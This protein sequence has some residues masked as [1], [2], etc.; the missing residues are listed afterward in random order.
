M[1][2][3]CKAGTVDILH[4][5]VRHQEFLLPAHEHRPTMQRVGHGE[6]RL[7]EIIP[8]MSECRK[9]CPMDH[10]LLLRCAPVEGQKAITTPNYLGVEVGGELGPVIGETADAQVPA[11]VR[12]GKVDILLR[13]DI[14]DKGSP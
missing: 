5:M 11:Q 12:R 7:L 9:P 10:V 4:T 6:M 2:R 3:T 8:H 13:S 14:N 1:S